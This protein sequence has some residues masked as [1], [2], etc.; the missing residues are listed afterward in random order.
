MEMCKIWVLIVAC[1]SI[2]ALVCICCVAD[3][4]LGVGGRQVC[5]VKLCCLRRMHSTWCC[6]AHVKGANCSVISF[7]VD[8][9]CGGHVRA[10]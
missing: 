3:G 5:F 8:L 6:L 1:A 7:Y 4:L 10:L 2:E 9:R